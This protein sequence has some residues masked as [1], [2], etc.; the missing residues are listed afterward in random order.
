MEAG[1]L[2][3]LF[4]VQK[5][6][7]EVAAL[8]QSLLGKGAAAG[9]VGLPG[10]TGLAQET[11]GLK[12]QALEV[13]AE[14]LEQRQAVAAA[15]ED[16]QDSERRLAGGAGQAICVLQVHVLLVQVAK[17]SNTVARAQVLL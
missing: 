12:Q 15:L 17:E 8:V 14:H 13:S 6:G 7:A 2:K 3:S 4:E 5:M 1:F 9:A 11:Q 10:F 16:L